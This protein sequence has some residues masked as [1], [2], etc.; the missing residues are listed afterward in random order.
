[1]EALQKAGIDLILLLQSFQSPL[2]DSFFNLVTQFGG[3]AYV[4]IIP[5]II[6]CIEPRL[7]LR[8]LLAMMISQY[9]VMLLKDIVQEPRPFLADSRIISDGEHGLSFPSGHAM[10]SFVFYG[11]LLMSTKKNW[12]KY[13]LAALIFLIGVSRSYLG[14]HYPHDVVAGWLLAVGFLALWPRFESAVL[15]PLAK[16]SI[17]TQC[18]LAFAIPTAVG[19]AHLYIFDYFGALVVAAAVSVTALCL[20]AEFNQPSNNAEGSL[21]Q[22]AGRY[23][24][25]VALTLALLAAFRQFYPSEE[26]ATYNVVVWLN[27][28]AIAAMIAFIAPW[29]FKKVGL[30]AS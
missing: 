6:W 11:M 9:I 29:I 2:L 30:S 5:L 14:V 17:V 25:G 18:L 19:V 20:M 26:A 8:A 22:K 16:K 24:L 21:L 3:F 12:L 7:G 13:L 10:G 15:Q 28:A 27:G 1:M 23:V 4:L